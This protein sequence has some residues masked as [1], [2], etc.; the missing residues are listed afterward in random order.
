MAVASVA[1]AFVAVAISA[2][3]P[4]ADD[5]GDR[6]PAF[7]SPV[8]LALV[9]GERAIVTANSAAGTVSLVERATGRRLAELAVGRKPAAVAAAGGTRAV[10]TVAESGDLVLLDT[11]HGTLVE[12]GRVHLGFEPRGL[13]VS[14]D[15]RLAYVAVSLDGRLAAV[16]L[17]AAKVVASLAVG[18]IPRHV[19]GTADGRR[20]AV[21]CAGKTE[22]VIVDT[23][24]LA[25]A[26]RHRLPGFN[27]GQPAFSADGTTVFFPW[28]YD[29]GSHPSKGNI[30]RGWVTGSRLGRLRLAGPDAGPVA[31]TDAELTGLSL[32]VLG[33]AAGDVA[34]VAVAGSG[35][36]VVAAGGTHELLRLDGDAIPFMQ[37]S[38]SEVMDATLA[39]DPARFRRL[40]VAGRPLG[41]RLAA[42]GR[43]YVANHLLDAV[44]E[45][46]VASFTLAATF[47]LDDAGPPAAPAAAGPRLVRRGEAI[48]YDAA[49]SFDQW[50]SCHTCHF[51]GGGNS[52]TFDTLNDGSSG[53]YKTVLPLY[54]L[55][56][57]G[58]W[59]WHGWQQD[60]TGAVRR[61]LVETMQ[62]PEPSADDVAALA[63]YLSSLPVPPSP[64]RHPDGGL[65][66]AAERGRAIFASD[67]AACGRCHAGDLLTTAEVFDVGLSR[68]GDRFDG[69]NPPILAGVSRK[70]LFL[71][72]GREKSLRAVLAGRHGP[73]RVS[74][75][76]P[77]DEEELADLVAYLES[78]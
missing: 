9:D 36:L 11:T 73:D 63:A 13:A 14:P 29:G 5:V 20:L 57:T 45:I 34:A 18:S 48:F 21:S 42:D 27:P 54:R 37:T 38:A 28:T 16:D 35:R 70:T 68:A 66:A 75:L 71:H 23:E 26:S 47:P 41:M 77:L 43:L 67:R 40:V 49:R 50:Y 30:R 19:A 44:Q 32:D 3:V 8:D 33:R 69:F 7:R 72:D 60:L 22:I 24:P 74:G 4:A 64:H 59:T 61:S 76:P 58:P 53:S 65:S 31:G 17:A 6:T 55:A 1:A 39:A 10:V 56:E 2:P 25:V 52:V 12:T 62:G 78:L 15:G 46:D 51:E